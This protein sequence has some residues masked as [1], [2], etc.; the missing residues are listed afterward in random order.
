MIVS[1]KAQYVN[2]EVQNTPLNKVL[3]DIWN[4]YNIQFSFN[5][6]LL[7][8]YNITV[9][10]KFSSPDKA[11]KE[12][13]R[14][15]PLNYEK[16]GDVF[17]IFSTD[18][19]KGSIPYHL[20]GQV[21]ESGSFEPLPYSHVSVNDYT[22]ATD[23]NG[24]F[25]FNSSSDSIFSI[26]VSHLGYYLLDTLINSG[27]NQQFYLQPSTIGLAEVVIRNKKVEKSTQIG[28]K[29][30]VTKLNHK[31][32]NFL[33]GFGDNSVINLLRLHPGILA[34]GEQTNDMVIWGS[35]AGHSQIMFDG[36]PIYGLKNFNDNISAF[37]PLL[38]KN[39]E[40]YKGGYDARF[41]DRVGGIVNITSKNGNVNKPSLTF[42]V[43]N[44]TL[45]GMAELPLFGTGSLIVSYRK[46][47]Y[48]LYNNE[49][50]RLFK[51]KNSP[52][53]SINRVDIN[54]IPDYRFQD[55]NIKY[56]ARV[57]NRDFFYISLYGGKDDFSYNI[58]E[59]LNKRRIIKDKEENNSQIGGA[60]FYGKTWKNANS[61]NL[62]I[63]Y[64]GSNMNF[65]DKYLIER[66][67]QMGTDFRKNEITNNR[68]EEISVK[69]D[70][71]FVIN[72]KNTIDGGLRFISN[73]LSLEETVFNQKKF[74][75][76]ENG[77]RINLFIQDNVSLGKN[78][79]FKI[80]F[81]LNYPLELK[82]FYFEPRL[83]TSIRINDFWKINAA[84]GIYNQFISKTSTLDNLGN[85]R[86]L[87]TLCNNDDI[88]V[89]ESTHIVTGT[90]FHKN[91]LTFSLEGYYKH[92]NGQTQYFNPKGSNLE[93]IFQGK[94]RSYG[95]DLMLKKDYNG[96]SAWMSYSLSKTEEY[97]SYF[98]N[99]NYR[100][101][102]Q[103]QRHE[104]K[105]A[106]LLNINPLYFSANYVFGSGFPI[107]A[108]YRLYIGKTPV[109]KRMDVS[110]IYKFTDKKFLGE[111][112][113][114]VLNLFNSKNIKF[115]NFERIPA[116]Q[117][118]SFNIHAET[119]P[120]TPALY[121]KLVF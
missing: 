41:G 108:A 4:S 85:Y 76:S 91:D 58:D 113:L 110:L 94:S 64:S 66:K 101:S 49:N 106:G 37:N 72:E 42:C 28:Q 30:G 52:V 24:G 3:I 20:D 1:S 16:K 35:Y 9:S 104:L 86:Y 56:S 109:Y 32:A 5:D 90:S 27:S 119:I 75:S 69:I 105:L 74:N 34:A 102:P 73:Q 6:H 67:H 100:R 71:R 78:I 107:P 121:L 18:R 19:N 87:W 103:D 15:F 81:R 38:A 25:A 39:I 51:N 13:L 79:N 93:N 57:K 44:M 65:Y 31:I 45:N 12:L 89:L 2:V 10:K 61:S 55:I 29:A 33:P 92:T 88:P 96:H 117:S 7:S 82:K 23:M 21:L 84:W 50:F 115:S 80:G 70:N 63:S 99:T 83:S 22:M 8:K 118:S 26:K 112:G 53:D 114:S 54:V 98:Q 48:D 120:F 11:I 60:L 95:L 46:T 14:G 36:F 43:N 116:N 62:L 97:F 17:V 40:I 59:K 77:Q 111:V 47:Y 68:I